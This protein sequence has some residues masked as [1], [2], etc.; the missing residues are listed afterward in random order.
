MTDF[1]PRSPSLP[2]AT[3]WLLA[4]AFFAA[5]VWL[6][7]S[8]GPTF[9]A[10]ICDYAYGEYF[11]D[12]WSTLDR[13][14]LRYLPDTLPWFGTGG[15][16][17]WYRIFPPHQVYPLAA[18][19]SALCCRVFARGLDCLDAV[20]A[21]NLVCPLAIALLAVLLYRTAERMF[22]GVAA[23]GAALALLLNPRLFGEAMNNVK[24]APMLPLVFGALVCYARALES[25]ALRPLLAGAALTGLGLAQKVNAIWP[26]LFAVLVFAA[27]LLDARARRRLLAP[28]FLLGLSLAP[29]AA[30]AAYF[31]VSPQYLVDGLERLAQHWRFI[32]FENTRVE[33]RDAFTAEPLL[34][35]AIA[36]PL[37]YGPLAALGF[38]DAVRHRR[39]GRPTLALLVL[40]ATVP[41]LRP[42]LPGMRYF[43]VI[44]HMLEVLPV[45]ALFAGNGAAVAI[46]WL[47]DRLGG[48]RPRA[49]I[50]I[51]AAAAAALAAPEVIAI[52]RYH[53]YQT[54]YYNALIGGL[55]GAQARNLRDANDYW[56]SS[57]RN[58]VRWLNQHAAE[59]ALVLVPVAPW[60]VGTVHAAWLRQDLKFT[61]N[62]DA[63]RM[64]LANGLLDPS[65]DADKWAAVPAAYF[66]FA[67]LSLRYNL[68]L[69]AELVRY[70]ERELQPLHRIQRDGGDILLVYELPLGAR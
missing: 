23:L 3:P 53:P 35:F 68:K 58:G 14:R 20:D 5:A 21:H 55:G 60:V 16:P 11:L 49:R 2:R 1:A 7:P 26:P 10:V 34:N 66:M 63:I 52:A 24:D 44:R 17:D 46:R 56:C 50:V 54:T 30:A 28:R 61:D 45:L 27:L 69:H 64:L 59:G 13:D 36:T 43:N 57:Y 19:L 38:A 37:V 12:F 31:A 22:G 8:Y 70:C 65:R 48:E 32:L 4:A 42:C 47:A 39:A 25:G 41:V 6:L 51:A 9:D 29:V 33:G 15:H 62:D 18:T 40:L 67:P